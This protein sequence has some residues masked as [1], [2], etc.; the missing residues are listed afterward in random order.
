MNKEEKKVLVEGSN[1][2]NKRLGK[3]L[4]QAKLSEL[5]GISQHKLS[6]FELNK[7]SLSSFEKELIV[8]ILQDDEVVRN[9]VNRKKRYKR[10]N[11]NSEP[12]KIVVEDRSFL[13][14]RTAENKGYIDEL[15]QIYT[16]HKT[17]SKKYTAMSLF[18]GCGGFSL[19]FSA[20][21]F[22]IKAYVE[23]ESDLRIIYKKNHPTS[24]ELGGDILTVDKE[25]LKKYRG[26]IDVIIGG[27]P[28]Q[29]FSLSGKRDVND[30]RNKLFLN[31]LEIVDIVKPKMA[32]LENV[33]LLNTMK[34]PEGNFVKDDIEEEFKLHGYRVE[35]FYV[36]AKN[37]GVPQNRERVIFIA[38]RED[39]DIPVTIAEPEYMEDADIFMEKI[40][41]FGDACSDLSFLESGESCKYDSLHKAVNH[42]PHV[43]HWLWNV[44]EGKSAHDNE[45][46]N[47]RPPSGYNTTYKRQEWNKPGA[48]V[49]TTF[50]MISGSNNVHPY[51]TR[52]LTVREAA[53][54]QSFPDKYIF[55][56]NIGVIRKGIGN[57]VPP[58]MAYKFGLDA[59]KK[60][61]N[62]I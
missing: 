55:E 6:A 42:P 12:K 36:N 13:Q 4:S 16:A 5:T 46:H 1:I 30:P 51:A 14:I 41:T 7:I 27:P 58:L 21:G 43:I 37:Y 9:I 39:V 25:N 54:L 47:L 20:A 33:R 17:E 10:T 62:L 31:Y 40:R 3:K 57:A 56:G 60:L 28:C 49:Q 48:T 22:D 34:T 8:Q 52:S 2:R 11:I 23:I 18:A 24:E 15:N 26:K 61:Q 32:F 59:F 45:D 38:V 29:G 35:N 44:P 53:R 50:G 19:G